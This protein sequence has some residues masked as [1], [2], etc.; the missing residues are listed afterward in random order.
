MTTTVYTLGD[1]ILMAFITGV[2]MALEGEVTEAHLHDPETAV[3]V[4][5]GFVEETHL[6]DPETAVRVL[7]GFVEETHL[8]PGALS[9]I[10]GVSFDEQQQ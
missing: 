4:L 6:H 9:Q 2:N 3:R 7:Q 1:M 5:Q 8:Q 10:I